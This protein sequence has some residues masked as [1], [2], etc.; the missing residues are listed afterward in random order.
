MTKD[1]KE[2][3]KRI[4]EKLDRFAECAIR[5]DEQIK[6]VGKIQKILIG[7]GVSLFVTTVATL[8][9]AVLR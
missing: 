7:A 4:E 3:L 8:I 1:E 2:I 5:H 6:N 9:A